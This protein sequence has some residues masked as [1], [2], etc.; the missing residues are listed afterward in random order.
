ME[1]F[2]VISIDVGG[3]DVGATPKPPLTWDAVPLLCF[4]IP[5]QSATA[6][7]LA[8]HGEVEEAGQK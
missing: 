7:Y 8:R 3:G 2:E 1:V 5:A 6:S 4:K